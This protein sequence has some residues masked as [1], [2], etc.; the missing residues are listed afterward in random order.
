LVDRLEATGLLVRARAGR[1]RTLALTV[2]PAGRAAV[3]RIRK[4]RLALLTDVVDT[5]TEHEQRGLVPLVERLL[6]ELTGDRASARRICR[7]CDERT[8]E[9]D[10]ACPVDVAAGR[11]GEG[12]T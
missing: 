2:T 7:L 6:A 9:R 3:A 8:C 10:T 11:H 1:G 4:E 5:L 12:P